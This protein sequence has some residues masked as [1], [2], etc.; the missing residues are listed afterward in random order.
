MSGLVYAVTGQS[1]DEESAVEAIKKGDLTS[2]L[3]YLE[4]HPDPNCVFSTGKSGLFYAILYD[5]EKVVLFLLKRGADPDFIVGKISTLK[6]AIKYDRPRIARMLIEYG[7]DVNKPDEKLN[8]PLIYAAELNNYKMCKIMV[9]RGADPLHSNSKGRLAS[10]YAYNY[11]GS[12]YRYLKIMEDLI[13]SQDTVPSMQDGPYIYLE[14]DDRIVM[15]YYQRDQANNLT[16]LKEKTIET[17]SGD[18][19]IDGFGWDDKSY[20][21]RRN[22]VPDSDKIET[23]GDIFVVGDIHGKYDQ[24]VHLLISNKIID[25]QL[26]W[27]FGDG[28][29]VFLGDLFDRGDEVTELL[30]FLYE[31][32]IKARRSGGDVHVLLGNHEV[33]AMTGDHRYLDEKYA[34]FSKYTR[35]DYFQLYDK[36]TL[37]GRWLR[38]QNLIVQI[39]GYL[40]AHAGISPEFAA[41][42][43]SYSSINSTIR[44]FLNSDSS[45]VD[46]SPE[47]I[48]LGPIGPQWYRGYIAGD[49]GV[50][51]ITQQ[52]VD[53]YTAVNGLKRM[54]QG[55]NEQLT[56]NTAFDGKVV[57]ADVAI[58][59][60][61]KNSQGLLISGDELYRCLSDG[62]KEPIE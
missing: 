20:H 49:D 25:P 33:M 10:D 13:L 47:D 45:L 61:G 27:T 48:I 14:P 54:I 57:F 55:H 15:T 37:L 3:P 24:L 29:L 52:F 2:L 7:A 22:F 35:I 5:Q 59:E 6:W 40:F 16:E 32:E 9:N 41:Y 50:P 62:R 4:Q 44:D 42:N 36:N 43:Y 39:N 17:G 21:I 12:A 60:A 11:N 51:E 34:Y 53:D 23:A 1:Q 8:T 46:A 18:T 56:I 26:H 19:I 38:S 28:Q 31:L 58:D 30:W